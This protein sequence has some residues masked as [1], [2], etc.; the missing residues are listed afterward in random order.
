[1]EALRSERRSLAFDVC[2]ANNRGPACDLALHQVGKRLLPTFR[3]VRDLA[4]KLQQTLAGIWVVQCFI[5]GLGQP[6]DNWTRGALGR[7]Q[8]PPRRRVEAQQ[9]RLLCRR[10]VREGWIAFCRSYRVD[11]DGGGGEMR[12]NIQDRRDEII[13]LAAEQRRHRRCIAIE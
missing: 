6:I 11:L 4:A 8:S 10:Y 12:P 3:F 5:K 7:K 2:C 13:D 1:S 9:P